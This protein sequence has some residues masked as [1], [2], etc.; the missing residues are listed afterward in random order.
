MHTHMRHPNFD[1][2]K[3]SENKLCSFSLLLPY[4]LLMILVEL[5]SANSAFHLLPLSAAG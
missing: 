5:C 1:K 4:Y 2:Q 3:G